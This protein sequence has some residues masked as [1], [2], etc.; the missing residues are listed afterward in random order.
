MNPRSKRLLTSVLVASILVTTTTVV[1][2]G[3]SGPE[4]NSQANLL[5]PAPFPQ[6]KQN[7]PAI[8]QNPTDAL[9]LIAGANDE[10]D[11]PVCTA[12]GCPFVAN[13]GQSGVY[14]SH[15]G[16]ANW[17]QFA[18]PAGGGNTASFNGNTV[19]TLPG[20]ATLASQLGITGLAS[21]GDPAIAFS[22]GGVAYYASLAGVRGT[23][24]GDLI[25]VS[26]SSDEGATWSDPVLATDKTNPVDFNDKES[27]WV[28]KSLTSSFSG[29][30]YVSWTL[31]VGVPGKAEPIVFS[32]STDGGKTFSRVQKL[33]ASYNNNSVGGR[34]GSTI[35]TA[36]NGDVY[37]VWESG[38][39]I[40]GTKTDAQ[41]FAK[42]TD[43]GETF[44]KPAVISPVVDLPSPLPG[45]SFR[46][47]SFPTVD[48]DQVSGTIYVAWADFRNGRGQIMLSTSADG[49]S[50]WSPARVALNV[51][52]RS[53]FFPGL[54]VSPDGTRVTV[55]S[56]ALDAV[57]AGRKPGPGVVRYDSYWTESVNGAP[58]TL[59][60][61][62]STASSDPDGSS[63]NSL[64]AQFQ[65]DYN[66]LISDNRHA[67]FIW[68][69]GR[70]T[71]TCAAVDAFR[72]G[73]AP[74]PNEPASCPGNFGNTD[75]IVA[76]VTE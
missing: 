30:V 23:S 20:F 63:T 68:T 57:S 66:T 43:G 70:N 26:R 76:R 42:S 14:I 3:S 24:A 36:A 60:L 65:G 61:K 74:K 37:V 46:N 33:S 22:R 19:H 31:F 40:N 41:V 29:N 38:V 54:A 67:W 34:Q 25:T 48:I 12:A 47:D 71:A 59:P 7:E 8:A 5:Q 6:N 13:V 56:Q 51:S 45:A 73:T 50:S 4:F 2:A 72:A 39:S 58:F 69:D 64:G 10:I 44:S 75:I 49:G 16:G 1:S 18:A 15:D 17:T 53:A 52:G 28:D 62:I 35:R 11:E 21:D 27:V 9:N 32:R 55:A